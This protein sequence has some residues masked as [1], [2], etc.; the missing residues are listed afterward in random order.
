[1]NGRTGQGPGVACQSIVTALCLLLCLGAFTGCGKKEDAAP[2]EGGT[3][4]Q[5]AD[6]SGSGYMDMKGWDLAKVEMKTNEKIVGAFNGFFGIWSRAYEH[7][8]FLRFKEALE[9]ANRL[10]GAM[11]KVEKLVNTMREVPGYPEIGELKECHKKMIPLLRTG[12]EHLKK[13]IEAALDSDGAAEKRHEGAY[14]TRYKEAMA[15]NRKS[16]VIMGDIYTRGGRTEYQ[17]FAGAKKHDGST[18]AAFRAV[19]TRILADYD[20]PI[21][22]DMAAITA[23]AERSQWDPAAKKSDELYPR[24]QRAIMEAGRAE[25][26]DLKVLWDARQELVAMLSSRLIEVKKLRE[27]IDYA[28]AGDRREAEKTKRLSR[29]IADSA[30]QSRLKLKRMGY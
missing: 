26:G 14:V 15:F 7:R 30:A 6:S 23:S 4:R 3:L 11:D 10:P 8:S 16:F 24:L 2:G 9:E 13:S 25:P 19:M 22:R 12:A 21:M 1:M 5:A 17:K 20:G 18:A 29:I 28:K 27:Y